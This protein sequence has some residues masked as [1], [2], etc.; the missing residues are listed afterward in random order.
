MTGCFS[1]STTRAR[2]SSMLLTKPTP[3]YC[4]T[5]LRLKAAKI[6][7]EKNNWRKNADVEKLF[8][9]ASLR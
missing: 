8:I 4:A 9:D 1:G 6:N 3:E 2:V 5:T 7:A